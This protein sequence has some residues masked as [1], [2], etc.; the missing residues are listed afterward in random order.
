MSLAPPDDHVDAKS[1][2]SWS[3]NKKV[4]APTATRTLGDDREKFVQAL[5]A[6]VDGNPLFR[7]GIMESNVNRMEDGSGENTVTIFCQT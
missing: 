4:V 3:W 2:P 5:K 6:V 1:R 7:A